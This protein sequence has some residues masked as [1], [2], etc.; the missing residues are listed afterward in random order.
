MKW[1]KIGHVLLV[2][3]DIENPQ[4]LLEMKGIETVV[5]L[6]NIGGKKREPDVEILAGSNTETINRENG[7]LFKLDVAR[8]M[9]SKGN[10]NERMRI[11]NIIEEGER[12]LDMFAGIGYF[13]IPAA[14]HSEAEIIHAVEIN[15]VSYSYLN[16]NVL[17]NKVENTVRPFLGDSMDIAPQFSVDRVLM[18]YIGNTEDFI[19][20]AIDALDES[21]IIHYHE[22]VYE[23]IKFERPVDRIR[24]FA[25]GM[26]VEILNK[27]VIKKY[28]PGV[29][30]VVIDAKITK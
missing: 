25:E 30:H 20:S 7:C 3:K 8:V 28:S 24:K 5:K 13:T 10:T 27:R 6:G 9:W 17:L 21:G 2:D 18:G 14:V 22:S 23:K 16:E 26:D 4:K 29:V 15:P 19:K 12:V 11:A 1:K